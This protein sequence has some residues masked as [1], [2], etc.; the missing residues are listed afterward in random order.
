MSVPG[1]MHV[2]FHCACVSQQ[3]EKTA[4]SEDNQK[5]S[6]ELERVRRPSAGRAGVEA[7][8]ALKRKELS[9]AQ[10]EL[11]SVREEKERAEREAGEVRRELERENEKVAELESK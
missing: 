4:M 1:S 9:S 11:Q 8:V 6:E 7:E 5:L 2:L 10:R 3:I